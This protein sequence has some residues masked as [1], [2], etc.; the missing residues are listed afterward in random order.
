MDSKKM[1]RLEK[2]S[3]Q[4]LKGM[5]MVSVP[6]FVRV[7]MKNSRGILFVI[8]K[9]EVFKSTASDTYCVFGKAEIEDLN[10]MAQNLMAQRFAKQA[11]QAE[12]V[13]AAAADAG[14]QDFDEDTV[15]M[16]MGEASVDRETAVKSLQENGGDMLNAILAL[17]S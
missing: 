10:Q 7:T 6:G 11:P 17:Q 12:S 9:P 3:R 15:Q 13:T 16:V 4:A 2:K 8:A 5:G 14:E 1:S